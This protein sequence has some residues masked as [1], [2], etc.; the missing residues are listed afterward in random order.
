MK[1]LIIGY[2][3]S[4]QRYHQIIKEKYPNVEVRV[5]SYRIRNKDF[6]LANKSQ[7]ISFS[8]TVV[9][10]CNPSS[11]RLGLLNLT[12]SAKKI[13]IEKP[14]AHNLKD[15]KKILAYL[16]NKKIKALGYNL[17]FYNILNF[18]KKNLKK[19]V[20][21]VYSFNCESG[22]L[23]KKWRN[24]NYLK[25][26]SASKKL[27]GGA[28]LELSHE[29]DYLIWIFGKRFKCKGFNINSKEL[30]IDVEDNVKII[31][32][33]SN[34]ILGSL[35]LDFLNNNK[36]RFLTIYGNKGE[37]KIDLILNNIYFLKKNKKVWKNIS[38]IKNDIKSSYY[39][40]VDFLI[41]KN[42]SKKYEVATIED[43]VFVL[44]TIE[45]LK[46]SN[47]I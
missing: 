5:F 24:K 36:K 2:G 6:F 9:F 11:K 37:L 7:I 10:F 31:F 47:E 30:N 42:Y 39:E 23:L 13:F 38:F 25:S 17:R 20:G 14:L 32:N 15:G 1:V 27:G 16:K 26:V 8:P 44:K 35:S 43:G 40:L 22:Y 4:G 41:K 18:I 21:R 34:K 3:S 46:K 33:F 28:L 19:Y 12:K 29:L 45:K